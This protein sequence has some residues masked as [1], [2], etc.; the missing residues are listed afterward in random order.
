[1]E[2]HEEPEKMGEQGQGEEGRPAQENLEKIVDIWHFEG[3]VQT[4]V[5]DF[6]GVMVNRFT[7]LSTNDFCAHYGVARERFDEVAR[8]AAVGLD[9][10]ERTEMEYF[11]ELA[12]ALSLGV[13][14]D[15]IK[16]FFEA[17]DAKN[18]MPN[19]EMYKWVRELSERGVSVIMATN[20]SRELAT[21]LRA[22]GL[23]DV[24]EKQFFSYEMGVSKSD[25][26][27]WDRI[28][29]DIGAKPEDVIFIDDNATN[30]ST[31]K[32][33]GLEGIVFSGFAYL[34]REI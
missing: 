33:A 17:A 29:S 6:D 7:V 25:V 19:E 24:F 20:V 4:T 13:S 15:E 26:H 34:M 12:D 1:M 16:S 18:I 14:P 5:C 3:P 23:Y 11:T 31:A 2:N 32:K 8:R 27:F 9:V 10:G 28:F 30:V 21:R 22:M